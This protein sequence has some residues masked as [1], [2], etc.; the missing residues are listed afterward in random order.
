M[1]TTPVTYEN[2]RDSII[3]VPPL[4]RDADYKICKTENQKQIRHI[5][6]GGVRSLLYG[7][8]ANLY[9]VRL[10][11]YADLLNML[12]EIAGPETL[13]V[14]SVGPSYGLM[15]DQAEIFRETQFPTVMVLPADAVMTES[16]LLRGF[17]HFVEAIGRP[18]VLYIKREGYISPEGAAKL[19][20]DGLVSFIKYAIV[21]EDPSV[22]PFLDKL[23][24]C[25]DRKRIVSGIGEQPAIVHLKQFG[26]TGFTSG[27][28]CVAPG[29]SQQMLQALYANDLETAESIRQTFLPLEDLRNGINPIRVL[30]QA[31][32]SAGIAQTGPQIPL[33][34]EIDPSRVDEIRE[35]ATALM[36]AD[37]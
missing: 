8:N 25:V 36:T 29:L 30:H 7:G 6:A 26:I 21:R 37:R 5:E 12:S 4:C 35:A 14:P 3:A 1:Q 33:L 10:S 18:A 22:D 17:R 9:H 20:D 2:L 31:V 16:G 34:D 11:E 28:V 27:C 15:M 24:E 19:V 32:A 23:V 13:V